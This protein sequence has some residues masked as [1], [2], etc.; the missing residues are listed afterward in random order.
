MHPKPGL[1]GVA[2]DSDS[3]RTPSDYEKAIAHH[4]LP[5]PDHLPPDPD[6]HLTAEERAIIVST[7]TNQ[8]ILHLLHP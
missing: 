1:D 3:G 5:Q 6:E 7:K 4:H 2:A 8:S